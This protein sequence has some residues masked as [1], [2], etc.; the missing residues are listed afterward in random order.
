MIVNHPVLDLGDECIG[1]AWRL[2]DETPWHQVVA[3][4]LIT[5]NFDI[6]V[7][8]FVPRVIALW[9][10]LL[11]Q[12]H[13]IAIVGGSDDHRA[14]TDTGPRASAIGSPTTLVLADN[15]SEAAIIDALRKG[16]TIVQLSGPED[17]IVEMR[18]GTAEIGDDIAQ[19]GEVRVEAKVSGGDATILQL[20]RDGENVA[21]KPVSGSNMTVSFEDQ[22]TSGAHRYRLELIN[23]LNQRVVVTSH[24]Y[25][26][27]VSEDGCGCVSRDIRSGWVVA[28]VLLGLRRRRG[29]TVTASGTSIRSQ[30]SARTS[31][32]I[33]P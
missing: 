32:Q 26:M 27:F 8:A 23:D 24:I 5:G 17:P 15:L 18:I 11:D 10:Q 29:S 30:T 31:S 12:G 22:P 14:G 6:A 28:L 25:V 33:A 19:S 20:W 2:V 21:Q 9:D 13:R 7:Q 16:R 3:L 1:C 4:E